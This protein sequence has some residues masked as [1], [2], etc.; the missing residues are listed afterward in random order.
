MNSLLS[1]QI[2]VQWNIVD[3]DYKRIIAYLFSGDWLAFR[4]LLHLASSKFI[5]V[6]PFC[7]KAILRRSCYETSSDPSISYACLPT[8]TLL[9]LWERIKKILKY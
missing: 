6:A 5:I 3:G 2:S 7:T 4:N 1:K 8:L 9:Y